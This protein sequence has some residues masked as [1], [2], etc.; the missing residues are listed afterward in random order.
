MKTLLP[1]IL[2]LCFNISG[3]ASSIIPEVIIC[4]EE[5]EVTTYG[6]PDFFKSAV[7]NVESEVIAFT[8]TYDISILQI[9][10]NQGNM[11]FQLPVMSNNVLINKNLFKKGKYKLGFV[12]EGD[13]RIYFSSI[14][15]K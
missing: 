2:I 13:N 4:S 8:T 12:A 5:V 14:A 6:D 11:T 7:Y 9:F 3:I 1:L 10:D 15:I